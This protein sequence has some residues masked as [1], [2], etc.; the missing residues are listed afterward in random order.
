MSGSTIEAG[1]Y[2]VFLSDE[3]IPATLWEYQGENATGE[4]VFTTG[5][6]ATGNFRL[7]HRASLND[8]WQLA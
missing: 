5:K 3:A 2:G 1:A 4:H 8:F 7:V 6:L